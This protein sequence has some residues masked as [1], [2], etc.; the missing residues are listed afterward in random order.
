MST[1]KSAVAKHGFSLRPYRN[2]TKKD[3]VLFVDKLDEAFGEGWKFDLEPIT[4]GGII[5]T[6]WP[7]KTEDMYKSMRFSHHCMNEDLRNDWPIVRL[8]DYRE[9]WLQSDDIIFKQD[10][11]DSQP[12]TLNGCIG[13]NLKAFF[14][15]PAWTKDELRKVE[16]VFDKFNVRVRGKPYK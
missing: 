16:K 10:P 5:I 13:T 8:A 12:R 3:F 4:E 1:K 9:E 7:G 6:E 14:G 2:M 15:A 11:L